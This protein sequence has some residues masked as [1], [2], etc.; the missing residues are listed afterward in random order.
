[1]STDLLC[2]LLDILFAVRMETDTA[3]PSREQFTAIFNKVDKDGW[4]KYD[5]FLQNLAEKGKNKNLIKMSLILTMPNRGSRFN[6]ANHREKC[7]MAT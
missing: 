5:A 3:T 1:M 7:A 4:N 2:Y 6:P